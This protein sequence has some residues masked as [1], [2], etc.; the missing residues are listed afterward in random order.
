MDALMNILYTY[1]WTLY[2]NYVHIFHRYDG[3]YCYDIRNRIEIHR[4]YG[5]VY[6]SFRARLR[7]V[8]IILRYTIDIIIYYINVLFILLLL[9]YSFFFCGRSNWSQLIVHTHIHTI[10]IQWRPSYRNR[11]MLLLTHVCRVSIKL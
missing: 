3:V 5:A 10:Y 1:K 6:F 7:F 4:R 11:F 8:V 2:N 9:P